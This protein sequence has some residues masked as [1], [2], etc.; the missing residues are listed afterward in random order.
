MLATKT[1]RLERKNAILQK[2]DMD[3]FE[4]LTAEAKQSRNK[5]KRLEKKDAML[6]N[7]AKQ[8]RNKMKRLEKKDEILTNEAKN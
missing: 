5:M 4:I 2:K 7:E 3:K 1:Q 6:T 8:S